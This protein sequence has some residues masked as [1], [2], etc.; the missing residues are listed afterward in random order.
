VKFGALAFGPLLTS[1]V[2]FTP[3]DYNL[4]R[5]SRPGAQ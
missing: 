3:Q 2:R 5:M 1:L 4:Y